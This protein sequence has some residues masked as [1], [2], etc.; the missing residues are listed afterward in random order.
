[1][2]GSGGEGVRREERVRRGSVKHE[3]WT[4]KR[5]WEYLMHIDKPWFL[6]VIS[7]GT[8][9]WPGETKPRNTTTN[10]CKI[11]SDIAVD[12]PKAGLTANL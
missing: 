5:K 11:I 3:Q 12:N 10:N 2:R 8:C 7:I 1:V 9:D 6:F 4:G